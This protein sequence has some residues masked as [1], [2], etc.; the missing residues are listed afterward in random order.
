MTSILFADPAPTDLEGWR[1]LLVWL[2][3]QSPDMAGRDMRISDVEM[4]IALLERHLPKTP[5]QGL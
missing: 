4:Q 3:G 2:R 1:A 5:A